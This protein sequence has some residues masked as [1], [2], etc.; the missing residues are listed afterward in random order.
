MRK[1]R[2]LLA[3]DEQDALNLLEKLL[4]KTVEKLYSLKK[5]ID[6]P[7]IKKINYL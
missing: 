6:I 3:D 7:N 1:L 5:D 2:A 4:V